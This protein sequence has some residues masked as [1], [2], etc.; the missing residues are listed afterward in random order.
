[1]IEAVAIPPTVQLFERRGSRRKRVVPYQTKKS[2]VMSPGRS[3]RTRR[4]TKSRTIAPS[5]PEI[6]S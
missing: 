1:M 5:A 4:A 3:V 6:D 2:R